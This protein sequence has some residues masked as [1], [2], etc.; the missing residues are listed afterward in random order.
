MRRYEHLVM[1]VS[2]H[3]CAGPI[4]QE[5]AYNE[6][7]AATGRFLCNKIMTAMLKSSDT[8]CKQNLVCSETALAITNKWKE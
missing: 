2:L 3:T 6:C 4:D 7:F 5:F 1:E 8:L